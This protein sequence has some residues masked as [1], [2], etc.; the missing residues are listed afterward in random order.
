[1]FGLIPLIAEVLGVST[2]V[3]AA[4]VIGGAG[5]TFLTAGLLKALASED[6]D[7]VKEELRKMKP[8]QI[9]QLK[10]SLA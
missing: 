10:K 8:E 5:G 4:G 7:K 3:V 9:E 6:V 1:M 2:E